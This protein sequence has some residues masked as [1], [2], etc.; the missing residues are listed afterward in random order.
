M[1]FTKYFRIGKSL[2]DMSNKKAFNAKAKHEKIKLVLIFVKRGH[3]VST[4]NLLITYGASMTSM[5]YAEGTKQKY[6][7][8]ILGGEEKNKE[9]ILTIVSA[10]RCKRIQSALQSYFA[11]Y[12]SAQGVALVFDIK[13]LAGV[14]AY[15]FLTDY[16][17]AKQYEESK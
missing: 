15:K 10:S 2:R 8:D 6:I 12:P 13:S 4:N 17:G 16:E 14:L 7:T 1:K 3:G 11:A 5:F 9:A